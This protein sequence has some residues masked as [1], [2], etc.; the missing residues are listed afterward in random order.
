[1]D[2]DHVG[3]GEDRPLGSRM[4]PCRRGTTLSRRLSGQP[5]GGQYDPSALLLVSS[6]LTECMHLTPSRRTEVTT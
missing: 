3:A 2:L 5:P 6:H 4:R 1:M